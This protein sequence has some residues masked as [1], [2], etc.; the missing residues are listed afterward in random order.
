MSRTGTAYATGYAVVVEPSFDPVS[1][2]LAREY[3]RIDNCDT[4][5]I[6]QH[7]AAAV[8]VFEDLTRRALAQ[9][10]LYAYYSHLSCINFLPVATATALLDFEERDDPF[11]EYADA[12]VSRIKLLDSATPGGFIF[13]DGDVFGSGSDPQRFRVRYRAG[14]TEGNVPRQYT[15]CILAMV[16]HWYEQA[17]PVVVGT[18]A[19]TLP[20]HLKSLLQAYK[21]YTL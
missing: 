8:N 6:G 3:L 14:Y 11:S 2:D 7:L 21:V 15:Q 1:L 4:A 18:I 16:A 20:L 12:D 17:A 9:R 5:L 13:K 10:E 19:T